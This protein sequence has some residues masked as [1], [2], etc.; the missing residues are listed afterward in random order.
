MHIAHID[1]Y[2]SN[3]EAA[4]TFFETYF[5][6]ISNNGYHN[7]KTDFKSYFLSFDGHIC[8]EIMNRPG[9]VDDPKAT[10][11]TGYSHIAFNV[12]SREKVNELTERLRTDGYIV[13]SEPR[14]TGDGHY[15]SCILD[16]EGNII[17]I[18]A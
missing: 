18:T 7:Q 6:A 2:V 9:M 13:T 4:K 14:T 11:R 12:G 5:G 17:E 15:E 10:Y 3:L 16:A 8:I 1:M